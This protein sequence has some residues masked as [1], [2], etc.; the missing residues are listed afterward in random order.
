MVVRQKASEQ[1]LNQIFRASANGT[2]RDILILARSLTEM[3]GYVQQC[4]SS[5]RCLHNERVDSGGANHRGRIFAER[6]RYL[7]TWYVV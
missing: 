1:D 6:C 7:G 3:S 5:T 4:L 2:R